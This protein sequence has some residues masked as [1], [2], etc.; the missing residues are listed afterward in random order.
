MERVWSFCTDINSHHL[1]AE[2]F[3]TVAGIEGLSV[4]AIS[5]GLAEE[6]SKGVRVR[7]TRGKIEWKKKLR[8]N[9]I[10]GGRQTRAKWQAK[11]GPDEGQ[12]PGPSSSSSSSSSS[13]ANKK[14][15]GELPPAAAGG[16]DHAAFIAEF[17]RLYAENNAGSKPTWGDKPGAMVKG[18]LSK[19]PLDECIKRMTNMFRA[20]PDFPGPPYDLGSLVL[21]F[22]KFAQPFKRAGGHFKVTGDEVYAGGE[23]EI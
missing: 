13:R 9:A 19:H 18:L 12:T 4:A 10:K 21:H 3:D 2:E 14:G 5:V 7:G 17:T 23:V 6:T 1:S 16:S 15:E 11:R 22:D 20:P 8:D